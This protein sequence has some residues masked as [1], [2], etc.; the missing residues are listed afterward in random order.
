MICKSVNILHTSFLA[1]THTSDNYSKSPS[2]SQ[3]RRGVHSWPATQYCQR[4]L[5]FHPFRPPPSSPRRHSCHSLPP[6][7]PPLLCS[8]YPH[9]WKH[10][11]LS[12]G[13]KASTHEYT[14]FTW[15]SARAGNL[16]GVQCQPRQDFVGGFTSIQQIA[17]N[18]RQQCELSGTDKMP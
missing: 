8:C 2:S 18:K 9:T 4:N 5:K 10:N 13:T 14:Q 3:P 7:H 12:K 16:Q 11:G 15:I 6:N 17:G 1:S